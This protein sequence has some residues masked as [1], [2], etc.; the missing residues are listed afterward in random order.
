M[1]NDTQTS[2]DTPKSALAELL[3]ELHDTKGNFSYEAN[4][5][6]AGASAPGPGATTGEGPLALDGE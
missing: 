2:E 5:P 4:M 1:A 6:A 3:P